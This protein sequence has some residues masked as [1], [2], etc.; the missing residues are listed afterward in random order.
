[1]PRC[2]PGGPLFRTAE[3]GGVSTLL[4]EYSSKWV[5]RSAV[6]IL[7]ERSENYTTIILYCL[8]IETKMSMRA[9]VH[10]H[11]I[12]CGK[13]RGNVRTSLS[14]CFVYYIAIYMSAPLLFSEIADKYVSGRCDDDSVCI[15]GCFCCCTSTA[16]LSGQQRLE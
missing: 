6:N 9:Y 7:W 4:L 10:F 5:A 2:G 13:K 8:K 11:I 1:M 15:S 16:T 3:E 12:F 14:F